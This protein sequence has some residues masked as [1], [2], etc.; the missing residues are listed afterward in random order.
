MIQVL[1]DI[2]F[3]RLKQLS[4]SNQYLNDIIL[5]SHAM[6]A[7]TGVLYITFGN[8]ATSFDFV[9]AQLIGYLMSYTSVLDVTVH[10]STMGCT[11]SERSPGY[12]DDV[13]ARLGISDAVGILDS[14]SSHNETINWN[15]LLASPPFAGVNQH[16]SV[17]PD[18]ATR[19]SLHQSSPIDTLKVRIT[20]ST[21]NFLGLSANN[22]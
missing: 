12:F 3:L 8:P 22:L 10:T 17:V 2:R 14:E 5:Q 21:T 6:R 19:L 15:N 13:A 9:E 16:W 4:I 7:T 18:L 11:D 20:S 1:L